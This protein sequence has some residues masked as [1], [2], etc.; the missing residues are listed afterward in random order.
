MPEI[1][2]PAPFDIDKDGNSKSGENYKTVQYEKIVPLLVEAIKTLA[3]DVE[4]LKK[5][6]Q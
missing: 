2:R 5:K 4:E 3:A 6:L 1:I